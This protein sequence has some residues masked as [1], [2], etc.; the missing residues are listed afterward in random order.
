MAETIRY[1]KLEVE[2]RTPKGKG[3]A[4][5]LR[6][7]GKIPA[8]VYGRGQDNVALV[9]DPLALHKAT[10][11]TR[12]YNT[13]FQ[14][15]V[16]HNG[17][18]IGI[19]SCMVADVQV[20]PLRH[21]LQHIDFMRIDP[22]QDVVRNVPIRTVGRAAGMVKG[23]RIKVFHRTVRVA[24]K[25]TAIPPEIVLDVTPLDMGM[26]I[27]MRDVV[28]PKARIDESPDAMLAICELAKIKAEEPA[29]GAP[30]EAAAGAKPAAG[31]P[32]AGA[33]AA[34][35]AKAEKKPDKK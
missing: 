23:G 5:Q 3:A 34:A 13:F 16:S 1:G 6:M 14:L 32:A 24:A 21:N 28:L 7:A 8:V 33:A 2:V 29:P 11:P 26:S 12:S 18:Q 22:S 25:P 10:D 30:A 4:R 35:P 19:E 31:A 15:V 27:R 17:K 9:L 20:D